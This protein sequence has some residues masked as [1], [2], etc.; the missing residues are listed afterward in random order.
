MTDV[1]ASFTSGLNAPDI[2]IVTWVL[3]GTAAGVAL[4]PEW[5]QWA[6]KCITVGVTGD[7]FN[8]GTVLLEGSNNGTDYYTIHDSTG[9]GTCSFALG[10]IKQVLEV[11]AY[12][13]PR[14]S[15]SVTQVT[16]SLAMRRA[17]P[18]RI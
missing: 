4:G 3:T 6:D 16:V 13:R 5:A 14:A 10:G 8:S 7:A 18:S 12:I 17:Q 2:S 9:S 15:V 11:P 1:N